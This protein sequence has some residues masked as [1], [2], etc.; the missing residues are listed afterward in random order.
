MHSPHVNLHRPFRDVSDLDKHGSA[1]GSAEDE[2]Q[3]VSHCGQKSFFG[4]NECTLTQHNPCGSS[5]AVVNNTDCHSRFGKGKTASSV[6]H[7]TEDA[8]PYTLG[9]TS[10]NPAHGFQI[11]DNTLFQEKGSIPRNIEPSCLAYTENAST[12]NLES[13]IRRNNASINLKGSPVQ[14]EGGY[15]WAKYHVTGEERERE[16]NSHYANEMCYL[17]S[18]D[19]SFDL[20]SPAAMPEASATQGMHY[21]PTP[22]PRNEH[23]SHSQNG[24]EN[25]PGA[26]A[27]SSMLQPEIPDPAVVTNVAGSS[28]Y[29]GAAAS[30]SML[31]PE[32]PDPA[33]VTNVAGSSA[34][35]G[36]EQ[37]MRFQMGAGRPQQNSRRRNSNHASTTTFNGEG[38]PPT[39]IDISDADWRC[40]WCGAA[41]WFGKVRLQQERD[42]PDSIKQ[43]FKDKHFMENIRA[44]NQMF[45][46]TSFG[47]QIN[48]TINNERGAY[49]FK[50]SGEIRH[51]IGALYPPDNER[52]KFLQLY[53]Y[54]TRN[55]VANRLYHFGGATSGSLKPEVVEH[56]IQV[57]DTHNELVPSTDILGAIV[58]ESGPETNTEYDVIIQKKGEQPQRINKLHSTYMALQFPLLFV[59]GQP[60]YTTKLTL[61][62]RKP[63]GEKSKMTMKTYYT[64]QIHE[65]PHLHGLLFK[66]GS[67]FGVVN[68]AY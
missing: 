27:S 4:H 44:Y 68:L 3:G 49:V 11:Y 56:L 41:F 22:L 58:F 30:S 10:A 57:L 53:I 28:A 5:R 29:R 37:H 31:Q 16:G 55:E 62:T 7:P 66:A 25:D 54:D 26:A 40:H 43:L 14:E 65:M 38:L 34:Y 36:E 18:D 42:P 60:G 23:L 45:S 64:Y 19:A 59:Y 15:A 46:M 13:S 51:Q 48:N 20:E 17:Y 9:T 12:Y 63:N 33:V 32:I 21:S 47:A 61:E 52:P 1:H 67:L 35:R 50:V 39:Y 8:T 6:L 2:V 24:Q